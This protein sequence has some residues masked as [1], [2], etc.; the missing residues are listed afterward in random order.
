MARRPEV[1]I[2]D[3]DRPRRA[4][5]LA[6]ALLAFAGA[7]LAITQLLGPSAT[8]SR[9][10][11]SDSGATP[12]WHLATAPPDWLV[13]LLPAVAVVVGAVT[14]GLAL[15]GRWR[16]TAGRLTVAGALV[17]GV[18]AML[19]P[20]GSADSLSYAAY[21]RMA[22]TGHD[23]YSTTPAGL[24]R[25]G[26]PV[27]AA[28][29]VPW[30][31]TSSV[32]GPIATAEQAAASAIAGHDVALTVWLLG[33]VN[34]LAF[35]GVAFLGLRL[36]A[37][38]SARRRFAA[39][40]S[41]NPL[42]WLAVG[43]GA[44]LD[45]LAALPAVGALAVVGRSR[46][47]SGVLAGAALS[48]KAPAG[49]VLLALLW[50]RRRSR[51]DVLA[52]LA[53]A[54]LVAVPGYAVAGTAAFHQ[55]SRASRLVSLATPWRLVVDSAHPP[56]RLVG[57]LAFVLFVLLVAALSRRGARP[58]STAAVAALLTVAYVLA[59]PYA[60]PWYDVLPW[61]LVPLAAASWRDWVLLAHTTVLSLSYLPGRAAAVLG[62][63][64]H[65]VTWGMRTDVAP[66]L[67][68]LLLVAVA[69]WGRRIEPAA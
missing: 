16:P 29:E 62:R 66:V 6:A 40:W 65:D 47:G 5:G 17:V 48:V 34:A 22:A 53:G 27:A 21:G 33:L 45:V 14:V 20:I 39:L 35:A 2:P 23:P 49:L 26:D 32:Y 63:G 61:A 1:A 9:L 7:C 8:E 10:G 51:R 18:L 44:H 24:A 19:P 3:S 13:V 59:A 28:V 41:A 54:A 57:V 11:R 36:A 31:H 67:L 42:L 37:G 64:L 38:E 68:L 43:S 4:G 55:L 50:V 52:L 25:T 15:T 30:Q 56:R 60:L 69:T 58:Q 12:P 46:L